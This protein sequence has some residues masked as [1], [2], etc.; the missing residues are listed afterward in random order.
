[1]KWIID[2]R[3]TREWNADVFFTIKFCCKQGEKEIEKFHS[4]ISHLSRRQYSTD[5]VMTGCV[6]P[7]LYC[8][9]LTGKDTNLMNC[10]REVENYDSYCE[11]C[12]RKSIVNYEWWWPK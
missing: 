1:M 8:F 12:K 2:D 6:I 10:K 3:A 5:C 4:W 11:V 9:H 7:L